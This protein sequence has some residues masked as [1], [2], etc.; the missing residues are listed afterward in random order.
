VRT[1]RVLF[2]DI[3]LV[4]VSVMLGWAIWY[5]VREDLNETQRREIQLVVD[6]EGDLD[7][8]PRSQPISVTVQGT[9]RAVDAMR[10][11][12][13]PRV[14]HRLTSA[15]L[16]PGADETRCDFGKD[17]LDFASAFGSE[18]LTV[19][20]MQP[21]TVSVKLFRVM[22]QTVSVRPPEFAGAAE[23]GLRVDV[24][25]YSNEAT[26][27]GPKSVLR[28]YREILTI[29]ERQQLA[30]HAEGLRDSPKTFARLT[31][32]I[33]PSQ[34]DLFTVE[35]PS[36]LYARVELSRV[37]EQEVMLPIAIYDTG[38]EGKKAAR[39]L[40]FSEINKPHFLAGDPP[41]VRLAVTGIP[42]ALGS[43]STAGLRAF[44]LADDLPQDRRNGDVPVHVAD[45]PPGVALAMD[46]RVDV[47]EAR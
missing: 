22:V 33:D 1:V 28:N 25:E 12:S 23:L 7:V 41:R 38:P 31:L 18:G 46:Y 47:E 17:D 42:A 44:V 26:V 19:L 40:Q 8:T 13:A 37:A 11:M 45:L 5:S 16:P 35:K 6:A 27:R 30:T 39:R 20:E 4:G 36:E 21:P 2:S 24:K 3:G 29:V 14:T 43:I 15:D 10:A 32:S 34:R 9:R